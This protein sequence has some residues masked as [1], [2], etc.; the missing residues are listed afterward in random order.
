MEGAGPEEV[1]P[2]GEER[3]HSEKKDG[4]VRRTTVRMR[5]EV[6]E[7]TVCALPLSRDP[8]H[9]KGTLVDS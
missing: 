9:N 1:E 8:W 6:D 5:P 7:A 3:A 2:S 4:Q